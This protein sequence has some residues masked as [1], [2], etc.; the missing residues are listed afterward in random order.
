MW[1]LFSDLISPNLPSFLFQAFSMPIV[2]LKRPKQENKFLKNKVCFAVSG[3]WDQG[4]TLEMEAD[5][6]QATALPVRGRTRVTKKY[7]KGFLL[8]SSYLFLDSAFVQL[9]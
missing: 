5:V 7:C 9:L 1:V 2:C 6:S 3:T 8:F 4:F